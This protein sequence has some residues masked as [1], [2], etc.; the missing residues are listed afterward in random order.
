MAAFEAHTAYAVFAALGVVLGA[1]YMLSMYKRVFFGKVGDLAS[2]L[3]D[4][5][6]REIAALSLQL[7]TAL[8]RAGVRRVLQR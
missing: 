6:A 5:G 7:R 3:R 2:S 4:I 8:V 1:V